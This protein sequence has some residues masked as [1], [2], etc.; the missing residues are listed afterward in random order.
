MV[1]DGAVVE[2]A[3]SVELDKDE[4]SESEVGR[5]VGAE[6]A[7]DVG[8]TSVFANPAIEFS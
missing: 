1:G 8:I 2:S 6:V 5:A 3:G 4:R 7:C